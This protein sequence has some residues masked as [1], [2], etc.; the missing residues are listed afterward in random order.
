MKRLLVILVCLLTL[1]AFMV[2]GQELDSLTQTFHAKPSVATATQ[3]VEQATTLGRSDLAVSAYEY[4][5]HQNG[6]YLPLSG[7]A[8]SAS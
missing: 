7:R 4:L 5:A 3:L 2:Q 1:P 8:I 6:K